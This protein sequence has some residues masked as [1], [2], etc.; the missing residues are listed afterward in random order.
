MIPDP[1]VVA[2]LRWQ[3]FLPLSYRYRY[4]YRYGIG[5]VAALSVCACSAMLW[6]CNFET[7]DGSSTLCTMETGMR[8]GYHWTLWSAEPPGPRDP[9][10]HWIPCSTGPSGPLNPLLHWTPLDPLLHWTLWSGPTPSAQTGPSKAFNG[11]Y[12]LFVEASRPSIQG[13]MAEYVSVDVFIPLVL[14]CN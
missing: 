4:R 14:V 13:D 2:R 5:I 11:H 7:T 9:L 3:F 8:G 12:Y 10:V 1:R 6:M